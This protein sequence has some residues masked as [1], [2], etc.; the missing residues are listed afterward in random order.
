[1]S[2]RTFDF[3]HKTN[4][5]PDWVILLFPQNRQTFVDRGGGNLTK[6]NHKL[7]RLTLT[8]SLA[9]TCWWLTD[10]TEEV[11]SQNNLDDHEAELRHDHNT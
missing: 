4:L 9:S 8:A 7:A 5:S 1:M 2:N 6:H 10:V 11:S 3:L